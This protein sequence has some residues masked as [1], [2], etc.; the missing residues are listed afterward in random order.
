MKKIVK[1]AVVGIGYFGHFHAQKYAALEHAELVAVVDPDQAKCQQVAAELNVQTM[2]DYRELIN[3]VDAVSIVVPTQ[4]H[5]QTAEFFLQNGIHVL[6]EKPMTTTLKDAKTLIAL[7][8]KHDCILQ[9]GH[10]ERFNSV[11]L[12]L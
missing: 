2:A 4:L 5:Y 8:K 7:A 9:I 10:L 11:L 6:L 3:R 12:A 1:T